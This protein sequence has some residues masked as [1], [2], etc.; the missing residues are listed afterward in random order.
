MS[1]VDVGSL[2]VDDSESEF[3]AQTPSRVST[4]DEKTNTDERSDVRT[5][6]PQKEVF[7]ADKVVKRINF[8]KYVGDESTT[9]QRV[10]DDWEE[11]LT[12][13]GGDLYG[14]PQEMIDHRKLK[15]L[16]RVEIML[17]PVIYRASFS[18]QKL[19]DF[20]ATIKSTNYSQGI[21][22]YSKQQLQSKLFKTSWIEKVMTNSCS[23]YE[24]AVDPLQCL[25]VGSE[26][27]LGQKLRPWDGYGVDAK[28]ILD[29]FKRSLAM[30]VK[31]LEPKM[32]VKEIQ[33]VQQ[34][35]EVFE[36]MVQNYVALT[37]RRLKLQE[38]NAFNQSSPDPL[39]N[40]QNIYEF[41]V[42]VLIFYTDA[43]WI[44]NLYQQED[45]PHIHAIINSLMTVEDG[46]TVMM[47]C[48]HDMFGYSDN[49]VFGNIIRKSAQM[50]SSLTVT[51]LRPYIDL[52][53]KMHQ[54]TPDYIQ[55]LKD[56]ASDED[57]EPEVTSA[58]HDEFNKPEDQSSSSV[59]ISNAIA[60][61]LQSELQQAL[62]K[63][64]SF[65]MV[66]TGEKI[67]VPTHSMSLS[68]IQRHIHE[69]ETQ[70]DLVFGNNSKLIVE[71]L[72][73][74]LNERLKTDN[75]TQLNPRIHSVNNTSSIEED[76]NQSRFATDAIV[77]KGRKSGDMFEF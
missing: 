50:V 51:A 28:Y 29:G 15:E 55:H 59:F 35:E 39:P 25:V 64:N 1:K 63:N 45:I 66:C 22:I 46:Q 56:S 47:E 19:L 6:P 57:E 38:H 49:S 3:N 43:Y 9:P 58:L 12:Q 30:V 7:Y 75:T 69:N 24:L 60:M 42:N 44:V 10:L 34:L 53:Q 73:K 21:D 48:I 71:H 54:D 36:R 11:E 65:A 41:A 2:F 31:N 76:M 62:S 20:Q 74:V 33:F 72:A 5:R 16:E 23:W 77:F 40:I 61:S 67:V 18:H 68:N 4:L 13:P 37:L 70:A 52:Q 8:D 17:K 26:T 32:S 27:S 14:F